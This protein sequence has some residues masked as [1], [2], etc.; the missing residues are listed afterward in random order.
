MNHGKGVKKMIKFKK[1]H[2]KG[3]FEKNWGYNYKCNDET[4]KTCIYFINDHCVDYDIS[5]PN[6]AYIG[7]YAIKKEEE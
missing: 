1:G 2:Y 4:C 7:V 3:N 6:Y 5:L